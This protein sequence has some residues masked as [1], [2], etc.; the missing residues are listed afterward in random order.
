MANNEEIIAKTNPHIEEHVLEEAPQQEIDSTFLRTRIAF[1]IIGLVNNSGYVI[2]LTSA[3]DIAD[4]F[5]KKNLMPM[6]VGAMLLFSM[7]IRVIN[8][9]FLLKVKHKI[10]I[11]AVLLLWFTG[12]GVI[13]FSISINSFWTCLLGAIFIGSGTSF[14]DITNQGFMKGF[15]PNVC[16]GY[17]SGTGFAGI[18]CTVYYTVLT[19]LEFELSTIIATLLLSYLIYLVAFL[20]VIRLKVEKESGG[21]S[22]ARQQ[23]SIEEKEATVNKTLS[24]KNFLPILKKVSYFAISLGL[25]YYFEYCAIT[26]CAS[27]AVSNFE[28]DT[29]VKKNAFS[30]LQ[31]MYQVGIFLSRSSLDLIKI[32]HTHYITYFQGAMFVLWIGLALARYLGPFALFGCMLIVGLLGGLSY[33]NTLFSILSHKHIPRSEKEIGLAI[34][35]IACDFFIL[36]SSISGV[37]FLKMFPED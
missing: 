21:G 2:I 15:D 25:V 20:W 8:A 28:T 1:F 34:S 11:F 26:F 29:F 17:A 4:R 31:F 5:G 6:F 10:R 3:Q 7:V 37:I 22:A 30:I 35:S 24:T 12:I 19:T 33:V 9:K 32:K 14:G 18:Y 13:L 27:R 36:M 23:E 16:A